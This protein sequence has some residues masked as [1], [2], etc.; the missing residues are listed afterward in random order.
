MRTP[1]LGTH[2]PYRSSKS[3]FQWTFASTRV[4]RSTSM[5]CHRLTRW[6]GRR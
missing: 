3:L 5:G 6:P 4:F 2:K 1:D